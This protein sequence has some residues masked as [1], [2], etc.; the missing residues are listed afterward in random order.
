MYKSIYGIYLYSESLQTDTRTY[1]CVA[2]ET[3]GTEKSSACGLYMII[4]LELLA[5]VIVVVAAAA[6][7]DSCVCVYVFFSFL[8]VR[9]LACLM[10]LGLG[11]VQISSLIFI[12]CLIR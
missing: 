3:V 10:Q 2:V 1:V 11:F 9:L 6:A 7:V 8:L 12:R 4:K 5:V